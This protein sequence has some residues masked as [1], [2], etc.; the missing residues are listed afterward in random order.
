MRLSIS[1]VNLN[2][3]ASI[4]KMCFTYKPSIEENKTDSIFPSRIP[5]GIM[6]DLLDFCLLLL[7]LLPRNQNRREYSHSPVYTVSSIHNCE[8]CSINCWKQKYKRVKNRKKYRR[9][10]QNTISKEKKK[11]L[12]KISH[13]KKFAKRSFS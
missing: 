7:T 8:S 2:S 3:A 4:S 6:I 5:S 9:N 12:P 10:D 11:M 1:R 13:K